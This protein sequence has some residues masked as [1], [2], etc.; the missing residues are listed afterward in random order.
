[1]NLLVCIDLSDS[2]EK[3][4]ENADATARAFNAKLWVI[5]V[6]PPNPDFVGYEAGPQSVRDTLSK[7]L[8]EEHRKIQEIADR[9]RDTG[10]DATALLVQGATVETILREAAKLE[11]DMIIAGSHGHGAM[12]QLIVGSV[13]EGILHGASCPVLIVPTHERS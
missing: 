12:Y 4:L 3:V 8:H 5:H 11:T 1:M 7:E 6:T 9:F 10:L 13:S 2:T